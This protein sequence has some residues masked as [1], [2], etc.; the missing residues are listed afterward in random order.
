MKREDYRIA[1]HST[2][3]GRDYFSV[4]KK[5]IKSGKWIEDGSTSQSRK[6]LE[7]ELREMFQ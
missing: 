2:N 4:Q 3:D 1:T 7:A 5:D 6:E